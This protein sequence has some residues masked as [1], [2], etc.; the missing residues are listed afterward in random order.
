MLGAPWGLGGAGGMWV[1][2][3]GNWETWILAPPLLSSV[4]LASGSPFYRPQ[5]PSLYIGDAKTGLRAILTLRFW[6][7]QEHGG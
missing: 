1:T 6:S 4:S 3:V 5:L 7:G 2:S